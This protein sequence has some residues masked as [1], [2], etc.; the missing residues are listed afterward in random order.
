MKNLNSV[1]AEINAIRLQIYEETKDM[2]SSEYLAYIKAQ[3][4]PLHEK[5]GIRPISLRRDEPG[6]RQ[7]A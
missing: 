2:S 6:R 3:T 4:T 5:Y 7:S 1:E